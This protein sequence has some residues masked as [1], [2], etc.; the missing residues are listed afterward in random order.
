MSPIRERLGGEAGIPGLASF[1]TR[2][3]LVSSTPLSTT[4]AHDKT[5]QSAAYCYRSV[6]FGQ[7]RGLDPA[8]LITSPRSHGASATKVYEPGSISVNPASRTTGSPAS[9]RAANPPGSA[10]RT[11]TASPRA[12]QASRPAA[13][14]AHQASWAAC[15]A[16]AIALRSEEHTSALQSRENLVC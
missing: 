15:P 16:C 4:G 9:T 7:P 1:F 11:D 10:V 8:L 2:E 13:S 14:L 6:I 12:R 3:P 5:G